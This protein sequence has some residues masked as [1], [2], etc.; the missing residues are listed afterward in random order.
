MTE[1]PTLCRFLLGYGEDG[2]SKP[3]ACRMYRE[4]TKIVLTG[5][6]TWR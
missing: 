4:V 5:R 2:V 3:T 6:L 1:T